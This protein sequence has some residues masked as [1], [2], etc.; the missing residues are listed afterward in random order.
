MVRVTQ[1]VALLLGVLVAFRRSGDST[2]LVG[3]AFLATIGVFSLTLPYRFASVWR[4]L[5]PPADLLLWIPFVSSVAIAAWAFSFFVIFP[6]VRFRTPLAWC[7][8]WMPVLPGLVG[9]AVFGYYTVVLRQPTPLLPPWTQSLVVVGVAYIIAGL[10]ALVLNYRRLTDVNERRR[11][12]VVDDRLARRRG[13]R[14]AGRAVVL[15]QFDECARSIV[16]GVA[17]RDLGHVPLPGAAA[18]VRLCHLAASAVRHR[19]DD[20]PGPA[21]RAGAARPAGARADPARVPGRGSAR[22]W[23]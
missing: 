23:R 7:A 10:A 18:V 15:E 1:L 16:S 5:P 14:N 17:V 22:P 9:Q 4:A 6:R 12:R 13:R 3:S 21:L 20:P 11:V 8:I 2:A 19:R